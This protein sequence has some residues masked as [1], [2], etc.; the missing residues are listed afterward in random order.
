MIAGIRQ[1]SV[2]DAEGFFVAAFSAFGHCEGIDRWEYR[3]LSEKWISLC[4][5][6]LENLG[7]LFDYRWADQLSQIRTKFTSSNGVG[8]CTIFVD[9]VVASSILLMKGG[10]A[11]AEKAVAEM[12]VNSLTVSGLPLMSVEAVNGFDAISSFQDRPLMV[13][14]PFPSEEVSEQNEDIVRELGWHFAAA[15]LQQ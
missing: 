7:D 8:I 9:E 6:L 10:D 1:Q 14:V 2:S 11:A 12:F 5:E 3:N 15:F 13:V 4:R